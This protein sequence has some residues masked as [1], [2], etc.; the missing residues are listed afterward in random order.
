MFTFSFKVCFLLHT[1][2]HED[3]HL[4]RLEVSFSEDL[5]YPSQF[6]HFIQIPEIINYPHRHVARNCVGRGACRVGKELGAN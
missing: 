1:C 2:L 5:K 3:N 4:F 6:P